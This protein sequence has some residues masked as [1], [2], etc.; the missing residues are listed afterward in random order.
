[1]YRNSF[2]KA[3]YY[4]YRSNSLWYRYSSANTNG[5]S[6]KRDHGVVSIHTLCHASEVN[7][8]VLRS[9]RVL[10]AASRSSAFDTHAIKIKAVVRADATVIDDATSPQQ[11]MM[12]ALI[13]P[14]KRHYV[15]RFQLSTTMQHFT[16]T[17]Y[18]EIAWI[19]TWLP[20][21]SASRYPAA[22]FAIAN[23]EHTVHV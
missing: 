23:K 14:K 6:T 17:L 7:K 12:A 20:T 16:A 9:S 4:F 1:M 2:S 8:R 19:E 22:V 15:S 5:H 11:Q 13:R 10:A 18:Y 21:H 3:L